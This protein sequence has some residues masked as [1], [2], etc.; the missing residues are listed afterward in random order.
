MPDRPV[1]RQQKFPTCRLNPLDNGEKSEKIPRGAR[2]FFALQQ[3][4]W[5]RRSRS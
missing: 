5:R 2:V 4:G 1:R 3:K